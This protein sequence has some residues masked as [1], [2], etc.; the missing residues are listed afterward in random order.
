MTY[1]VV[2]QIVEALPDGNFDIIIPFLRGTKN[3]DTL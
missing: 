2:P 3:T 1:A